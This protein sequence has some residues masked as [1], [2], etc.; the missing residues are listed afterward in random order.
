MEIILV[1]EARNMRFMMLSVS[2]GGEG[3]ECAL[4][5]SYCCDPEQWKPGDE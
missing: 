3:R 1:T 5:N 2:S 4:P